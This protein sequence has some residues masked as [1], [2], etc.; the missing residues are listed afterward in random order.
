MIATVLYRN[1]CLQ[2][3]C[4]KPAPMRPKLVLVADG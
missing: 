1:V 3:W 2:I 4:A